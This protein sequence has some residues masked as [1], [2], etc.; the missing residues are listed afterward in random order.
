M[1]EAAPAMKRYSLNINKYTLRAPLGQ[2]TGHINQQ[3][4]QQTNLEK[5]ISSASVLPTFIIT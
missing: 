1:S 5:Q 2:P 3:L 4:F